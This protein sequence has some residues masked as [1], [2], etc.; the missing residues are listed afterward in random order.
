MYVL[1]YYLNVLSNINYYNNEIPI[2][3]TIVANSYV[4]TYY[5][6][7]LKIISSDVRYT[8]TLYI[9]LIR[10]ARHTENNKVKGALPSR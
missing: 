7:K 1:A 8:F 4:D 9:F 5:I 6:H 3:W 2:Y 10:K